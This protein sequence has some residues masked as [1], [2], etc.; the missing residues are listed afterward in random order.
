[1]TDTKQD[2]E[3]RTFFLLG[4]YLKGLLSFFEIVGG[5]IAYFVPISFFT[6]IVIHYAQ[7]EL[8]EEPGD[9]IATHF[10]QIAQSIVISNPGFIALYLISRGLIKLFL[11]VALLK[12][13]LWAYPTSLV[14]LALFVIYQIYQIIL[15]HSLLIVG[16]TLFDLVVIYL[17]WREYNIVR[18]H[19]QKK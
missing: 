19:A 9:F 4:I 8:L 2:A 6:G 3:V 1:M 13:Q 5:I 18:T 11:I 12:N 7:G 16:I 17:I 14:V 15:T 10:L